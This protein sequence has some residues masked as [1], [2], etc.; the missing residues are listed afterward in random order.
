MAFEKIVDL[1]KR[2]TVIASPIKVG[3]AATVRAPKKDAPD[4][5]RLEL[6]LNIDVLNAMHLMIGDHLDVYFDKETNRIAFERHPDGA[7]ILRPWV[8][9]KADYTGSVKVAGRISLSNIPG[10]TINELGQFNCTYLI[11]PD[12]PSRLVI[13]LPECF[14]AQER[15]V[16]A[17]VLAA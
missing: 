10:L 8:Y 3:V 15:G 7:V 16:F 11:H 2:P 6:K 12:H 9:R 13:T 14:F 5:V 17:E 1:R 4:R